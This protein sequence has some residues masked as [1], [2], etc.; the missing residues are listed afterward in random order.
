[1]IDLFAFIVNLFGPFIYGRNKVEIP[2]GVR[3]SVT[4]ED[5]AKIPVGKES[6]PKD[7]DDK[8]DYAG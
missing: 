5:K 1:M 6:R 3:Q 8:M 7:G 4:E 2:S